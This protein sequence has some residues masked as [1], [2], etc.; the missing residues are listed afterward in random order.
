M[1][2]PQGFPYHTGCT[3]VLLVI[4]VVLEQVVNRLLRLPAAAALRDVAR[5]C[6]HGHEVKVRCKAVEDCKCN[7][8]EETGVQGIWRR[9]LV[10]CCYW[11]MQDGHSLGR[12]RKAHLAPTQKRVAAKMPA[13]KGV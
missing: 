2:A 10:V 6:G 1:L 5:V 9:R 7:V 8:E 4:Y 11:A 13:R 12:T 3:E